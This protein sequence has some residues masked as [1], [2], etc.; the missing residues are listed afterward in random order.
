MGRIEELKRELLGLEKTKALLKL[1]QERL[2]ELRDRLG[3]A[4]TSSVE[5]RAG[6]GAADY[7]SSGV[8]AA[9]ELA[10][11]I[12]GLQRR[13]NKIHIALEFLDGEERKIVEQSFIRRRSGS[14]KTLSA[15]L[16]KDRSSIF[17]CANRAVARMADLLGENQD[18]E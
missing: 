9:D 2:A 18:G 4:A 7:I 3:H 15:E 1:K 8:A 14:I 12:A 11:E 6:G 10:R 13:I 16:H 17:R 5:Q